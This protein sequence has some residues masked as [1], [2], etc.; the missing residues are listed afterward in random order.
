MWIKQLRLTQ[1]RNYSQAGLELSQDIHVIQGA[2]GQGKTSL[3]E[4]IHFLCLS[5]SFKTSADIHAVQHGSGG[6]FLEGSFVHDDQPSSQPMESCVRMSFQNESGKSV[7]VDNK[8]IDRLSLLF[9]MYPAV[10]SSPDDISIVNGSPYDRRRFLDQTLSQI[11]ALYLKDLQ[12]Y[13]QALRQRNAILQMERIRPDMLDSW[14]L[15]LSE[16]G[17]RIIM[18]RIEFIPDYETMAREI[19]GSL[20]PAGE[21]VEVRYMSTILDDDQGNP[22]FTGYTA[23]RIREQFAKML[24]NNRPKDILRKSTSA[25]SHKDDLAFILNGFPLKDVGSQGQL[26]TFAIALKTAEHR[27]FSEHL[28]K[29]PILLLDDVLSELD[30]HRRMRLFEYLEQAHQVFITSAEP[31]ARWTVKREIRYWFIDRNQIIPEA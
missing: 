9:G 11:S 10:V 14:D 3:L 24:R 27:Y 30:A 17:S 26:K 22:A 29:R 15:T 1:F 13:R 31:K 20:V 19:Y 16:I 5:G 12:D 6:F 8:K 4:A 23:D 21:S 25:G 18:K 28:E 2:N 7:Y